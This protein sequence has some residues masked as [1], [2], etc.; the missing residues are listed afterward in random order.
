MVNGRNRSLLSPNV[1]IDWNVFWYL[2]GIHVDLTPP[3]ERGLF[4][5][6]AGRC[7]EPTDV[8]D[9]LEYH[10]SHGGQS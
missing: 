4:P 3:K 2:C 9:A 8:L 7:S 1:H 6:G 5:P 10:I